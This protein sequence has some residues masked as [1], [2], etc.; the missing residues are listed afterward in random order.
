MSKETGKMYRELCSRGLTIA[1]ASMVI[2]SIYSC[3]IEGAKIPS[4]KKDW[5]SLVAL[6]LQER[7]K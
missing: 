6:I 4:S 1:E 7:K 5:D 2:E 3:A